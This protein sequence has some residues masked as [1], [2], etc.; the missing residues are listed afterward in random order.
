MVSITNVMSII[1][2]V[3]VMGIMYFIMDFD[4][5]YWVYVGI[6]T[7][8]YSIGLFIVVVCDISLLGDI[9]VDVFMKELFVYCEIY[10]ISNLICYFLIGM[11]VVYILRAMKD[12]NRI[13]FATVGVL[14]QVVMTIFVQQF[15]DNV[16]SQFIG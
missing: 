9:S 7:L 15:L 6:Y 1:I 10:I 2:A 13:L 11:V 16:I 14:S 3:I 12:S 8:I 4:W 5:K